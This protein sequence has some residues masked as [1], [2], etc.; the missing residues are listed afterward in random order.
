MPKDELT[1][2]WIPLSQSFGFLHEPSGALVRGVEIDLIAGRATD[3][4]GE[5]RQSPIKIA[6]AAKC[7]CCN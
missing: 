3:C 1:Y 2:A 5:N 7:A 6:G 4:G